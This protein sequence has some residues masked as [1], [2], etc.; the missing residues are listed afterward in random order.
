[1]KK[2]ISLTVAILIFVCTLTSCAGKANDE[3]ST[4]AGDTTTA[5]ISQIKVETDKFSL[6]FSEDWD[7]VDV[8]GGFQL[9]K[10]GNEVIEVHIRGLGQDE[11][12]AKKQVE[13]RAQLNKGTP[14]KETDL[15]GEKFW[16]SRY[17]L[18]GIDQVFHAR[19]DDEGSMVSITYAGPNIDNNSEYMTI[20]NS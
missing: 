11:A 13:E 9:F 12:Y 19:M 10:Q 8:D 4:K 20:I 16:S 6:A 7:K 1:M 14:A 5:V 2:N 3:A 15:L 18:N 17:T